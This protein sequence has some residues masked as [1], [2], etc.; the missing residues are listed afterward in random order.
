VAVAISLSLSYQSFISEIMDMEESKA[1]NVQEKVEAEFEVEVHNG[2]YLSAS[3][4]GHF[5]ILTISSRDRLPQRRLPRRG[6]R[7]ERK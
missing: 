3:A 2:K 7:P 6:H 5:E 4:K 1:I